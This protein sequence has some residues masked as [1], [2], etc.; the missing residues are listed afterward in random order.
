MNLSSLYKNNQTLLLLVTLVGVLIFSLVVANYI[1][2]AIIFVIL[3]LSVCIP[4]SSVATSSDL[5]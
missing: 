4:S 2:V 1:L 5:E 3:A